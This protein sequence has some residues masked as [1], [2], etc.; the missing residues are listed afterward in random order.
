MLVVFDV[1][2]LIRKRPSPSVKL[3]CWRAVET[4]CHQN[5]LDHSIT[6][7]EGS[8]TVHRQFG[9][10]RWS[11]CQFSTV[12]T[13]GH[14]CDY[15]TKHSSIKCNSDKMRQSG[16]WVTDTVYV[17]SPIDHQFIKFS[18]GW[19]NLVCFLFSLALSSSS[20]L[21]IP[22]GPHIVGK[23]ISKSLWGLF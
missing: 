14:L 22:R 23:K 9:R 18:F 11:N 2:S 19:R 7:V 17:R 10:P 16:S 5:R 3:N 13:S 8:T 1:T 12:C 6:D 15:V 4:M 20:H 21:K